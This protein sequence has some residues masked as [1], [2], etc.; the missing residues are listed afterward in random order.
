M[1]L[2]TLRFSYFAAE[3]ADVSNPRSRTQSIELGSIVARRVF[4]MGPY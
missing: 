4:L 1:F 3:D 2:K